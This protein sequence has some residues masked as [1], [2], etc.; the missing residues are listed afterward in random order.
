MKEEEEEEQQT[1]WYGAFSPVASSEI[2]KHNNAAECGSRWRHEGQ[3][4]EHVTISARQMAD[5]RKKEVV[6]WI[7]A[8]VMVIGTGCAIFAV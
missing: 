4:A 5:D 8:V 3:V 7:N 6:R 1:K 2:D